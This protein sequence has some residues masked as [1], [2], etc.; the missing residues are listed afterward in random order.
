MKRIAIID[1]EAHA[2]QSIRSMLA[3]L[4]PDVEV[5]GEAS[6]MESGVQLIRQCSPQAVLL[7][8]S[9]D[10][11]TG[12]DLL[13]QFPRLDF[14]VVFTTASDH[15]A[16]RAFRYNAVDYL[17]KPIVPK[18]L[19]AAIDR[20]HAETTESHAEKIKHLLAGNR[21]QHF[22]KIVLSTQE[23]LVF[24][25]LD[26]VVHLE[27]EGNYTNFHLLNGERHVV[28]RPMKEFE[29]ILPDDI[30]FRIHQSHIVQRCFVQKILK[31]DGGFV[32]MEGGKKLPLANRRKQEFLDW[33]MHG[34]ARDIR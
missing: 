19:M 11:G 28:S 33:V 12:F 3:A 23:G 21:A 30:F 17:L 5:V 32:V 34:F 27:S 26:Q 29:E 13:D 16:L 8:I 6:C 31:E 24:L 10:D 4:C 15:F 2:R 20:L 1:D 25:P 14:K 18:E 9:M 7:D 22:S